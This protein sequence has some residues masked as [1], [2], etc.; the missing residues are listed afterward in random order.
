MFF[1]KN[2]RPADGAGNFIRQSVIPAKAGRFAA[3]KS[4]WKKNEL[5]G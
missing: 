1:I 3:A 2:L 5:G 4:L